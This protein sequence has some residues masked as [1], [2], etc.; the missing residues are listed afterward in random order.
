MTADG[1]QGPKCC[2]NQTRLAAFALLIEAA[3]R[4]AP[5]AAEVN[6]IVL[7]D[8]VWEQERI[9]WQNDPHLLEAPSTA[10][11]A[12][13]LKNQGATCYMN[14]LMQQLYMVQDF[15]EGVFD[16]AQ[17]LDNAGWSPLDEPT[18]F[19]QPVASTLTV[20]MTS[21]MPPVGSDGDA[22]ADTASIGDT[23]PTANDTKATDKAVA[24]SP[25]SPKEAELAA[26]KE[27][28][29]AAGRRVLHE[30]AIMFAYLG[31]SRK[32]FYDTL[33]FCQSFTERGVSVNVSEQHDVDEFAG[34]LF[35]K[36]EAITLITLLTLL[37]LLTLVIRQY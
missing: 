35:D 22:T 28:E 3:G 25:P 34:Q 1:R 21:E 27:V 11:R 19:S 31:A 20:P 29:L 26:A 6:R 9:E 15:R 36:L 10:A 33:P 4:D 8:P 14:S 13:G 32:R 23:D 12:A 24:S 30:L 2:A 16:A 37:N 5:C 18:P 17:E 7:N